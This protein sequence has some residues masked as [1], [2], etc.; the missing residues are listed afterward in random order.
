[1]YNLFVKK[2]MLSSNAA[3]KKVSGGEEYNVIIYSSFVVNKYYLLL[4]YESAIYDSCHT[5]WQKC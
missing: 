2:E 3:L 1:M 5:E 4:P